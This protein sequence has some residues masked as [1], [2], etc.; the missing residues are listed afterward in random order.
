MN[1]LLAIIFIVIILFIYF[2]I[3]YHNKNNE[4]FDIKSENAVSSENIMS[5]INNKVCDN[6]TT[7]CNNYSTMENV[8]LY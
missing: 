4:K 6:T 2:L 1:I 7:N 5:E 8:I 3:K